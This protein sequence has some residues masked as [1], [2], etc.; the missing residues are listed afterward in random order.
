M[1]VFVLLELE[2]LLKKHSP[3]N[4]NVQYD[5]VFIKGHSKR[6]FTIQSFIPVE[7]TTFEKQLHHLHLSK[8]RCDN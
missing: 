8:D 3:F 6:I 2:C 7:N 5:D 1:F 4:I